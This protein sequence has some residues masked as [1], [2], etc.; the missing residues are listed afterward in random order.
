[1]ASWEYFLSE[2]TRRFAGR[3]AREEGFF[4]EKYLLLLSILL[5]VLRPSTRIEGCD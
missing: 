2:F 4:L 1:M 3:R 5:V